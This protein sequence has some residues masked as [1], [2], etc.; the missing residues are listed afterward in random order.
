MKLFN[1]VPRYL[2]WFSVSEEQLAIN[3]WGW[4]RRLGHYGHWQHDD[5]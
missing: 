2:N 3:Y 1:R 5:D 4:R